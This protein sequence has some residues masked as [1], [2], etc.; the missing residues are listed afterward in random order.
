MRFRGSITGK[1]KRFIC[2]AKCPDRASDPHNLLFFSQ[3]LKLSRYEARHSADLLPKLRISGIIGLLP[4]PLYALKTCTRTT[5]H[6]A[7]SYSS[8]V[9]LTRN[10]SDDRVFG[11]GVANVMTA[12]TTLV[13]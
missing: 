4:L 6:V 11:K 9:T 1:S 13:S 3:G 12:Q 5:L 8:L 10:K 2:F 7:V